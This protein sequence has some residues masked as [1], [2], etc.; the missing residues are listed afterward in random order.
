MLLAQT[1]GCFWAQ[2]FALNYPE[3][4]VGLILCSPAHGHD[5]PRQILANASARGMK[6]QSA[7][8][9]RA[10]SLHEGDDAAPAVLMQTIG[11][12]YF[13]LPDP[14]VVDSV[15][16]GVHYSASAFNRALFD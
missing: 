13:H 6:E 11:Y 10:H 5:Y 14:A 12:A 9:D 8:L 2:E 15:F 1:R 4:I 3:T 16:A 7:A